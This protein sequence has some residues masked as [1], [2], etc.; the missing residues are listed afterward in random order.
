M[1]Y[2]FCSYKPDRYFWE[3][4]I[5]TRKVSIV[6]LSVFGTELGVLRQSIVALLLL[7]GCIVLEIVG[8]PFRQVT[9]AH[10]V[11]KRLELGALLVEWGTLWCGL[12]IH[13]SGPRS[14]G[15]NMFMTFCV[16][17]VNVGMMIWFL[18]VLVAA[19]LEEKKNSALVQRI[20][21]MRDRF[22]FGAARE[23][24]PEGEENEQR[25]RRES[26]AESQVGVQKLSH[27]PS[28]LSHHIEMTNSFVENPL[29]TPAKP[30]EEQ[31]A[32]PETST[33]KFKQY[34]AADGQVYYVEVDTQNSVWFLPEDGELL[35]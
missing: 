19:Y 32:Q 4:I 17:L 34:E 27:T 16:I 25:K 18:R 8:E 6:A 20:S 12:M 1:S 10:A 26:F 7:L 33:R 24:N 2:F 28:E 3:T 21:R 9:E 14:E 15:M 5:T 31:E 29:K 30:V 35:E 13:H 23:S 11:L 22:G